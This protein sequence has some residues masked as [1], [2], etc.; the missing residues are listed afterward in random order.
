MHLDTVH[1]QV[2]DDRFRHAQRNDLRRRHLEI[3]ILAPV[4]EQIPHQLPFQPVQLPVQPLFRETQL[5]GQ[6]DRGCRF[7]QRSV[8][9]VG[10]R[11]IR[12]GL[13]PPEELL[14]AMGVFH[15]LAP[16]LSVHHRHPLFSHLA[17]EYIFVDFE[18]L[19]ALPDKD[20]PRDRLRN[21]GDRLHD[22][23]DDLGPF[24]RIFGCVA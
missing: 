7:G 20:R 4:F 10:R 17:D 3:E 19:G 22:A 11:R 6:I 8:R 15:R 12:V 16:G 21:R 9:G 14:F 23:G 18:L 5:R 2:A 13:V 1:L 24:D